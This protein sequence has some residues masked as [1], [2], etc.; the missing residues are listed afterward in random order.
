MGPA[1]KDLMGLADEEIVNRVLA[2]IR[3]L[4]PAYPSA[5]LSSRIVRRERAMI[6][7]GPGYQTALAR[8]RRPI[9]TIRGLHVIG[10]YMSNPNIEA[11]VLAGERGRL[12]EAGH[13]SVDAALRADA[14]T[15]LRRSGNRGMGDPGAR[16]GFVET[17]DREGGRG[18]LRVR[19]HPSDRLAQ[20][21]ILGGSDERTVS[22][23]G[24]GE[25]ESPYFESLSRKP[26]SASRSP[27]RRATSARTSAR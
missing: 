2:E 6:L 8:F 26:C 23:R 4:M 12:V 15:V 10:D 22:Q 13:G 19:R 11:A 25:I 9:G 21:P 17:P 16:V 3:R 1:A 7:Y 14:R 20:F 18:R 24:R 5:T 27:S